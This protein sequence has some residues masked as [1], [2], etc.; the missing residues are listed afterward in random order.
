MKKE[1]NAKKTP[2]VRAYEYELPGGWTV[3]AGR[4]DA[5]NDRL[6]IRLARP[7]DWWFHVRGMPGSHVV[8]RSRPDAEADKETL[9]SAAAIAAYHSK[10]RNGGNVAVSC[11]RAVNVTKPR[12]A[13][14]GTVH[15]RKEKVLR[16]RPG[17]PG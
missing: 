14:P 2:S 15:I 6:S 1:E 9:E 8:L 13:K 5:D 17:L 10:A 16:V 11:T 3:L 4:T 7:A 12:G